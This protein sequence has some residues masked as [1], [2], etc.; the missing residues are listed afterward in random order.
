M[1]AHCIRMPRNQ[2]G[3]PPSRKI[4]AFA[5]VLT[6]QLSSPWSC[7][8]CRSSHAIVWEHR[9]PCFCRQFIE[10]ML[11]GGW[12]VQLLLLRQVWSFG[13]THAA[14]SLHVARLENVFPGAGRTQS[15]A[16]HLFVS[17]HAP[18]P[19]TGSLLLQYSPPRN[20]ESRI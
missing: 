18:E 6:L 3:E 10:T 4:S 17:L 13:H 12:R 15:A 7:A 5:L 14:G 2:L 20:Q 1:R 19:L 9:P 11:P 8:G 16:W